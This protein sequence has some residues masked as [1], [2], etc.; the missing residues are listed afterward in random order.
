MEAN[1]KKEIKLSILL[2]TYIRYP[3]WFYATLRL[4]FSSLGFFIPIYF[5][6]HFLF[7]HFLTC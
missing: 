3:K 7:C 4:L 2:F 1:L 6:A 5:V